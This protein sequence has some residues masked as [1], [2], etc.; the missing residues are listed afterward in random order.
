MTGNDETALANSTTKRI[1]NDYT[2][3][4]CGSNTSAFLLQPD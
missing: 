4:R 2:G 3:E 1:F